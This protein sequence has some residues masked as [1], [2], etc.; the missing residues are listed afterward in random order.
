[1]RRDLRDLCDRFPVV[2]G[3]GE[4]RRG[5][6]PTVV[7]NRFFRGFALAVAVETVGAAMILIAA[8]YLGWF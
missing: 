2:T 8:R 6:E 4:F 3:N 1:M 5:Y 7:P